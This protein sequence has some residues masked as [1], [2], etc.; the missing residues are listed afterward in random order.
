MNTV[1]Q[2]LSK[3]LGWTICD[4]SEDALIITDGE[5]TFVIIISEVD[6]VD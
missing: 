1:E 5:S 3:F 6:K 2:D 4:T